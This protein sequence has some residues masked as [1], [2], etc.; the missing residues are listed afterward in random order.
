V[1]KATDQQRR[2]YVLPN[3]LVDRIVAYQ[4]EIG[5]NSEVEAVRRLLDDALKAR[6]TLQMLVDRFLKRLQ[7]LKIPSEVAKEV[8][9]GHPL[10]SEIGFFSAD[11][12]EFYVKGRPSHFK[13]NRKGE[14]FVDAD[15]SGNGWEQIAEIPD[16]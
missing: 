2:V 4:N 6:D 15:N 3:D 8:L 11:A 7:S 14:I 16:R 9:V 5:F 1:A 10:I 13:I 12:V